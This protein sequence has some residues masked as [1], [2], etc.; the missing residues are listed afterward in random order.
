[1]TSV[2]INKWHNVWGNR[3]C[4]ADEAGTVLEK[5]IELDGFDTPLGKMS[6]RDWIDYGLLLGTKAGI[7]SKDSIFEVGCGSGAFI[8]PFLMRGHQVSGLDYSQNLIEAAKYEV[9]ALKDLLILSEANKCSIKPQF[10]CVLANHVFHYFPS[11][12]YAEVTLDRMI[13]KSRRIITM[14]ALPDISL[15]GDSEQARR[16][17]LSEVEYNK[18]YEGLDILYFEKENLL[19]IGNKYGLNTEFLPHQ[20]PGFVQNP[21]RFDCIYTKR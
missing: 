16:G 19:N 5:L 10:D 11:M 12:D 1:M 13:K 17:I 15:R 9:P 21:Y 6:E 20:M 14:T 8:Y 4:L 7:T 2:L 3:E 18:K